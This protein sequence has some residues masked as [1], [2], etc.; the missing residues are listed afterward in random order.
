MLA[1]TPIGSVDMRIEE[2]IIVDRNPDEVFAFFDERTNDSRW[3]NSVIESEWIDPEE[4][5]QLGRRG[6]MV[7]EAMGTREFEDEVVEYE[8]G[9]RVAHLSA[10]GPM[11]VYSACVTEPTADGTRVTM[12]IEPKQLPGGPLAALVAP[13]VGRG[14]ARDTRDDLNRLKTLLEAGTEG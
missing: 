14:L 3:M 9:H 13:F 11:V 8:P 7:M 1:M 4:P 5:T 6:R 2:S 12:V 10:S